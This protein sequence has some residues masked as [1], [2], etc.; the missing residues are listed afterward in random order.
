MIDKVVTMLVGEGLLAGGYFL[1]FL[2]GV[3]KAVFETKTWSWKK[4]FTDISKALLVGAVLVGLVALA[5]AMNWYADMLG[6]DISAFTDGVST[7]L[8]L[9][10]VAAGIAVYYGK[11][12][13]NALNF[14]KLPTDVTQVGEADYAAIAAPIYQF[15]DTLTQKRNKDQLK[16]DGAPEEAF[17]DVE[18]SEEDAGKG[19]IANT[20]PEPYRS[21]PKDSLVDPSLCYSRECVSYCAW[22]VA[23]ATGNWP[24]KIGGSMNA[25]NWVTRLAE[26]GYTTVVSKPVE[27]GKYVGVLESGTYGHVVWFEYGQ[28]ISEYNYNY[29]GDFSVRQ[30]NLSAYK[31]VQI[32]APSS[33][34]TPQ[35]AQPDKKPAKDGTVTYTYKAGDTFGQVIL[36]LGLKTK[37]GLWGPDGDVAYYTEQLHE[38]GIWGNIPI[39]KT[40]KL[41]P[42]K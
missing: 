38:Q 19:G 26:N 27:G 20:Y 36:D 6:F 15:M 23:E 28:T 25:K 14:F 2:T 39:G 32:V 11:A 31:W 4:M 9:G 41:T 33:T 8:L 10:G 42:R 13:R 34:P 35:P 18:V 21:A 29:Q 40:I 7:T 30:V 16:E 37:H 5:D 12:A 1:W 3:A 17:E 22:K 24:K